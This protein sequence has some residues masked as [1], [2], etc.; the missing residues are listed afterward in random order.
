MYVD[1]IIYLSLS[2]HT[3]STVRRCQISTKL[4]SRIMG[5]RHTCQMYIFPT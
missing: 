5:I 2:P 3:S 1:N 4:D